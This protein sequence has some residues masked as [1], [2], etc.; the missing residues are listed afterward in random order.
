M[1]Q[2]NCFKMIIDV[3]PHYLP[4]PE[5]EY[6][7]NAILENNDMFITYRDIFNN[8]I[9]ECKNKPRDLAIWGILFVVD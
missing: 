2:S 1:K 7:K 3:F 5:E 4:Y 8:I 6:I 9:I